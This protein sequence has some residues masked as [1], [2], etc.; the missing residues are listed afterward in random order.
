MRRQLDSP[1]FL[2]AL[3]RLVL[4]FG[5][6][7][8]TLSMV[9]WILTRDMRLAQALVPPSDSVSQNLELLQRLCGLKV[10]ASVLPYWADAVSELRELFNERNRIFHGVLVEEEKVVLQRLLKGKRGEQDYFHDTE[11][12][13]QYLIALQDKLNDRR[14]QLIDFVDDYREDE[15]GKNPPIPASQSKF[16]SLSFGHPLANPSINTDAVR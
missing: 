3:G 12:D 1:E 7:E 6:I 13:D 11:I 4:D 8:T 2:S 14:R 9:I 5:F 16:S 10:N 15:Q